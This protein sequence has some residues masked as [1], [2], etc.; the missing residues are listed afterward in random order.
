MLTDPKLLQINS[1]DAQSTPDGLHRFHF[2]PV[3]CPKHLMMSVAVRNIQ[4][5]CSFYTVNDFNRSFMVNGSTYQ[6]EAGNYTTSDL[7]NALNSILS[8]IQVSYSKIKNSLTFTDTS[9][10]TIQASRLLGIS[11]ETSGTTI[12]SDLAIDLSGTRAI[13]VRSMNMD[14]RSISSRTLGETNTLVRVPTNANRNGII[15]YAEENPSFQ[16]L[17]SKVLSHMI[18]EFLDDEGNRID[19]RGALFSMT[20]EIRIVEPYQPIKVEHKNNI[21]QI[22]DDQGDNKPGSSQDKASSL[23]V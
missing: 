1:R 16:T 8:P 10:M 19:F 13:F 14:Y 21:L 11:A 18:L 17:P 12:Q 23:A 22:V 7:T 5:P 9:T 20:L 2:H 15:F 3:I 6:I 4:L